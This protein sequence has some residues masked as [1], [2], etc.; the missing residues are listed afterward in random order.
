[1]PRNAAELDEQN[2]F[3]RGSLALPGADAARQT[4]LSLRTTLD[5]DQ[6]INNASNRRVYP[7]GRIRDYNKK[8]PVLSDIRQRLLLPL[9]GRQLD[10]RYLSLLDRERIRDLTAT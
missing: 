10:P 8:V 5:W 7:D 2:T 3:G 6:G 4:G 1:M 9:L